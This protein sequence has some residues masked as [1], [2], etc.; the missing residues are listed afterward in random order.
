MNKVLLVFNVVLL[1]ALAYLYYAFFTEVNDPQ[2]THSATDSTAKANIKI[3][4]FD[5]DTLVKKYEYAKEVND[6][7]QGKNTAMESKLDKLKKGFFNQ[8]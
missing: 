7:L 4:F 5:F 8:S 2:P 3:A 1:L 6:Y